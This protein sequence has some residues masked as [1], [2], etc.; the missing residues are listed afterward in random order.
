MTGSA[1]RRPAE[2]VACASRL[3]ASCTPTAKKSGVLEGLLGQT[4]P[5]V[6]LQ[7]CCCSPLSLGEFARWFSL[8]LYFYAGHPGS[9]GGEDALRMDGIQHR[10][11]RDSGRELSGLGFQAIG[12]SSQSARAQRQA[13]LANGVGH[14][15]LSDP[16][17]LL[18]RE[19]GLPTFKAGG[20]WWYQRLVLVVTGGR[21]AQA[22]SVCD[23][24]RSPAQAIAWILIH[25]G[26]SGGGVD[27]S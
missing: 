4:I 20:A 17:L 22:F 15:L 21:V 25:S 14:R 3:V 2:L 16:E 18:A 13:V 7:E 27:A 6:V 19:L 23:P 11:F 5:P 8:V 10:A 26:W 9:L 12:V 1:G 24:A